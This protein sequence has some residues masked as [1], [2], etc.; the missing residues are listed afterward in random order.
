M[1]HTVLISALS[2]HF[3][4]QCLPGVFAWFAHHIPS[5]YLRLTTVTT[6]IFELVI[7]FLYFFPNRK[8]RQV[9]FY[10]QVQFINF[11]LME[12]ISF[13]IPI[14]LIIRNFYYRFINICT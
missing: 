5:W 13:S 9:A 12:N 7:P 10:I 3:E 2:R 4:V 1:Y 14:I 8:V 11:T 6:I